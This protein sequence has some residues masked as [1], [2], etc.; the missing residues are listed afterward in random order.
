MVVKPASSPCFLSFHADLSQFNSSWLEAIWN[1]RWE[2]RTF[3]LV[4]ATSWVALFTWEVL[5]GHCR[6]SSTVQGLEAVSFFNPLTLWISGLLLFSFISAH[7]PAHSLLSSSPSYNN[8]SA[9]AANENQHTLQIVCFPGSS[10]RAANL[11]GD[12]SYH[13]W[14]FSPFLPLNTTGLIFLATS[15]TTLVTH[16]AW[17]RSQRHIF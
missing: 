12:L 16:S 8:S 17:P 11:R 7:R 15:H 9:K 14:Q 1:H 3:N 5:L 6:V 13:E 4:F 10:S 2:G